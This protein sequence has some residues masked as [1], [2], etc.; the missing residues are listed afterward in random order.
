MEQIKR[1][2]SGSNDQSFFLFGP[3]GV[4]KTSWIKKHFPDSAYIDLL[5]DE[6]F[7]K[8]LANPKELMSY[9]PEAKKNLYVIIDEIQKTPRLLDEV[10]R[11]IEKYKMRFVLTGSNARKL[12]RSSA[13]L[14]AGRALS[15]EMFPFTAGELKA[16]FDL[17]KALKFGTIPMATQ[18]A[19]PQAF[20]QSYV[21]T[22]LKEEIQAEGFTRN[23]ENFAR[24]LQI[25]SF[26][27]G[28][29]LVI[30]NI[31]SEAGVNRKVVEDYFSILR[32]LLLS[33]ELPIFTKRS[34]RELI[35]KSKFYFFDAGVFRA[36]R[37]TGPI[38]SESEINGHALETLVLNEI[39]AL[40]HYLEWNY[41]IS[42]WRTKKN[43]EVDFILYGKKGFYA[44]EVKHSSRI[45]PD[46][47]IS[48]TKFAEDYPEAKLMYIYGGREEKVERNI[49]F[50]PATIFFHSSSSYFS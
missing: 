17:S 23:I 50:I 6:I 14:L 47:L 28:A 8:L 38:D 22:Y 26:S 4:G 34:K 25:A 15:F 46:D 36:I 5:D 37:P 12:K 41:E 24:F 30:S 43:L 3:R 10:H 45:R 40:N 49:H 16:D 48:L 1:L 39:R 32:D 19:N 33:V 27:Q 18:V 35:S 29:P 20:L 42:Y 21:K 2:L 7:N 31:A 44:I 9:I 13:N 11:L